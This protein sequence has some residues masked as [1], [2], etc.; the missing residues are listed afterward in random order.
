[1]A[2]TGSNATYTPNL[3]LKKPDQTDFVEIDDL[4]ENSDI[5][6]NVVGGHIGSGGAA[7]ALAT[8]TQAGFIPH[9]LFGIINS[10]RT[11]TVTAAVSNTDVNT[12]TGIISNPITLGIGL[13]HKNPHLAEYYGSADRRFYGYRIA[14]QVKN[15]NTSTSQ[16]CSLRVSYSNQGVGIYVNSVRIAN[17]PGQ[18]TVVVDLSSAIPPGTTAEISLLFTG[19]AHSYPVGAVIGGLVGAEVV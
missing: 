3:N 1:M 4:N 8:D 6:D 2:N 11:Y 12:T 15:T 7:H 16:E 13:V 14:F 19:Q 18:N 9:T 5:L 17:M 10:V